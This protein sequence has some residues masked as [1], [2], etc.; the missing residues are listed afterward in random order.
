MKKTI[1]TIQDWIKHYYKAIA[2]V[3]ISALSLSSFVMGIFLTYVYF[4]EIPRYTIIGEMPPSIRGS[5]EFVRN[6]PYWFYKI[7]PVSLP[8]YNM[9]IGQNDYQKMIDALPKSGDDVLTSESRKRVWAKLAYNGEMRDVEVSFH[10][11]MYNNWIFPKKAWQ[12]RFKQSQSFDGAPKINLVLPDDEAVYAGEHLNIFRA[13]KMGVATPE[14]KFV[15]LRINNGP[16][17]LYYQKEGWTPEFLIKSF[18]N[19]NGNLYGEAG[20][21]TDPIFD[22]TKWWQKYVSIPGEENNFADLGYLLDLIKNADDAIFKKEIV[23]ILDMDTFYQWQVHSMLAGSIHQDVTHNMRIYFDKE[24][25]KFF[26]ILWDASVWDYVGVG[27]FERPRFGK[28]IYDLDVSYNPLVNRIL[29]IPEFL[30]ER[31]RR[32]WEYVKDDININEDIAYLD[33]ATETIKPAVFQD[34]QKYER[35]G[36]AEATMRRVRSNVLNNYAFL[37]AQLQ[38]SSFFVAL[39]YQPTS[40]IAALELAYVGASPI[41]L[42]ALRISGISSSQFNAFALYDDSNKNGQ[43]D[44]GDARIANLAYD[45]N[46]ISGENLGIILHSNRID[47]GYYLPITVAITNKKFFVVS[48]VPF[49]TKASAVSLDLINAATGEPV[50]GNVQ[51]NSREAFF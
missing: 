45:K 48:P 20:A 11:D 10:G 47:G 6:I 2:V 8:V 16:R 9:Y 44:W 32:L 22:S 49:A 28:V 33:Q 36:K 27:K 43:L 5:I 23:K 26:L 29:N 37:R 42:N 51:A 50:E 14:G 19:A 13:K 3:C 40:S 38:K 34:T 30:L 7:K 12:I 46:T 35:N 25:Q 18:G 4:Y 41:R 31:N 24:K 17:M 39:S 15:I 1:R 21:L